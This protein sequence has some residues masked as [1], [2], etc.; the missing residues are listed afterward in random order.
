MGGG[1]GGGA[2]A[3]ELDQ[4]PT[5]AVAVVCAVIVVISI[6]LEKLLHAIGEVTINYQRLHALFCCFH[7]LVRQPP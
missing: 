1:E 5:W 4:T 7:F 6:V 3:R 2:A